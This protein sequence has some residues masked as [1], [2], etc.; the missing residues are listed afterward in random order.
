[1]KQK[2]LLEDFGYPVLVRPS[3]VLGG[4]GMAIAYDDKEIEEYVNE[5]NKI[6]QEHPILVDKYMLGKELEVDAICD[7]GRCFDSRN[8]GTLRKSRS[9]LR[10]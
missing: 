9:S 7:R 8:N 6:E 5:I 10:R 4:Q 1:M 3:Y 2:K